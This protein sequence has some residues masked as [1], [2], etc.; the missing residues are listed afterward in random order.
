MNVLITGAQFRNKGAQSMLY[1]VVSELNTRYDNITLYYIPIDDFKKYIPED[2]RFIITY[3]NKAYL[4]RMHRADLFVK[5][6]VQ[7]FFDSL[8]LAAKWK[9]RGV[10]KYS[11][12]I[13]HVDVLIDI[14]GFALSDEF[15][16]ATNKRY[17]RYIEDAKKYR[18][19]VILMP[20]S[21]GP[22][23]YEE[24]KHEI[25]QKIKSVLPQVDLI[26][27]REREG[28]SY[29]E[30]IYHLSNVEIS[31]DTVLQT[32]GLKRDRIFVNQPTRDLPILETKNN[33]GIIPN[34]RTL[35]RGDRS[36]V[37]KTYEEIINKLLDLGRNVY[38]FNHSN[39]LEPCKKI[40]AVF[41][42]VEGVHL[43]ENEMDCIEY[44][45]FVQN[46]DYIITSRYHAIVHAYKEHIPAVILGW[47][48]KYVELAENFDQSQYVFDLDKCDIHEVL[49][50]VST[51]DS[52]FVD[53]SRKIAAICGETAQNTCF[54][55]C[56]A[57]LDGIAEAK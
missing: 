39:D 25:D 2:Y 50:A 31:L 45:E 54:D 51:M 11:D 48:V 53:E 3:D 28:K 15:H 26:F 10:K 14:S 30:N 36:K 42:G 21:F 1:S 34:I 33:V 24:A 7:C 22:F 32:S 29:L 49:K 12:V 4:D 44:S 55:K 38:I 9:A 40:Y 46:F 56:W 18:A 41:E 43:I 27:A 23:H 52:H 19:K 37:L 6:F 47:A 8:R 20:Q 57:I 35:W 17:L 13:K 5:K 16:P